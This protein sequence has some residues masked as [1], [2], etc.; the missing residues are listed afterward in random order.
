[1]W[2]IFV[3]RVGRTKEQLYQL[4]AQKRNEGHFKFDYYRQAARYFERECGI[5]K[6]FNAW[7]VNEPRLEM[8]W[9]KRKRIN[10][11]QNR[12][13]RLIR[14]LQEEQETCEKE[15]E[16]LKSRRTYRWT[17]DD[18]FYKNFKSNGAEQK[19][20]KR[21]LTH[22][23]NM[24]NFFVPETQQVRKSTD[25]SKASLANTNLR[26]NNNGL[27]SSVSN[28][29]NKKNHYTLSRSMKGQ[30]FIKPNKKYSQR[31]SHRSL[32][33]TNLCSHLLRRAELDAS[34]NVIST[35]PRTSDIQ[36]I[37]RSGNHE[38]L[39]SSVESPEK[40]GGISNR[41]SNDSEMR[42]DRHVINEHNGATG[43]YT[44]ERDTTNS[45]RS[46]NLHKDKT[47]NVMSQKELRDFSLMKLCFDDGPSEAMVN[48]KR[49][50]ELRKQIQDL[51][52]KE[53]HACTKHNWDEALRFRYM[54][55]NLEVTREMNLLAKDDL[56]LDYV[57]KRKGLEYCR[58]KKKQ[59]KA[60][61]YFCLNSNIYR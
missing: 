1:M 54:R 42:I 36:R 49:H 57:T 39:D 8:E 14:L 59:L 11:L 38:Y 50:F 30:D 3:N 10:E 32:E 5:A 12:R 43:S 56:K 13:H 40:N 6:Q 55:N 41:C 19:S 16:E 22:L 17:L 58:A 61:E 51:A 21:Y 34:S 52:K 37:Q 26:L 46:N 28:Q 45:H 27:S 20:C 15:I 4:S 18:G 2:L 23:S 53:L 33:D 7:S 29:L 25:C 44:V 31:Y 60:R 35:C 24:D 47:A 48:L 9:E